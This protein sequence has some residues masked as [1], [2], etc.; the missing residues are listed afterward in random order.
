MTEFT[1][2]RFHPE[3]KREIWYEHW[4]RYDVAS[5]LCKN[6]HVLDLACGEGYGSDLIAKFASS[7]IGADYSRTIIKVSSNK[8]KQ[9]N[10]AFCNVDAAL[11]PFKDNSFDCIVSFETI[12]HLAAQEEMLTE[13]KRVL[14]PNG[15]LIIS[16]PD[17][18]NYTDKTG[19][20]NP[21]HVK[22]LYKEDFIDL[23]SNK[24]E[25]IKI[26]GQK[27]LFS[28]L[29]WE[30]SG[31]NNSSELIIQDDSGCSVEL[32]PMYEIAICS[33]APIDNKI[34][35]LSVYSDYGESVYKHYDDEVKR[36]IHARGVLEAYENRISQLESEIEQGKS[37]F[38]KKLISTIFKK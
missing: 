23:L 19:Y 10:L 30:M 2:E 26:W 14:K 35:D 27:L 7:V 37:S 20:N 33:N 6:K 24:F 34:C 36:N 16:S 3:C 31:K 18:K 22:E 21:F 17:K 25:H 38:Y 4:H 15:F 12:E 9:D 1:G 32:D 13:F 5:K 29:I 11:I 28:S 8:Y